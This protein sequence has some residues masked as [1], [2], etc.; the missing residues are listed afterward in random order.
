MLFNYKYS[1]TEGKEDEVITDTFNSAVRILRHNQGI[2]G[3]IK[4]R[5]L[6]INP[7]TY[8]VSGNKNFKFLI[9]QNELKPGEL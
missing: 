1:D 3:K 4:C 6:T 2:E 5:D 8:Y 7:R 9:S